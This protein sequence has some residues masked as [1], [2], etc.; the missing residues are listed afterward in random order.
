M[1][2]RSFL[3]QWQIVCPAYIGFQSH[4]KERSC[5]YCRVRRNKGNFTTVGHLACPKFMHDFPRLLTSEQLDLC[6]LVRS[7]KLECTTCDL[8]EPGK[9]FQ[10]RNQAVTAERATE[11][12]Y[13]SIRVET[14]WCQ[15]AQ[16][17]QVLH[18]S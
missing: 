13:A 2:L 3:Q 4:Q 7:K 15:R 12:G 17:H 18:T 8:G 6:P 14:V 16:H 5:I 1:Q 11:P 9:E 10:G